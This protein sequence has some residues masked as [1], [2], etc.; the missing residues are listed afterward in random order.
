MPGGALVTFKF[1]ASDR[2]QCLETLVAF[3]ENGLMLQ[4]QT[5]SALARELLGCASNLIGHS[6]P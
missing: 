1:P 2:E 3:S 4:P 5:I 6:L